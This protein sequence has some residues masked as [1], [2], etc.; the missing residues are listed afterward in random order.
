MN[1][2]IETIETDLATNPDYSQEQR[3]GMLDL[4]I[5]TRG[6]IKSEEARIAEKLNSD[7]VQL[8]RKNIETIVEVGKK[9]QLAVLIFVYFLKIIDRQNS[10]VIS[11]ETLCELF[12]V[13]RTTLWKAQ[14][15]LEESQ[16]IQVVKV[17]TA[18]ACAIN[19][20][21]AWTTYNDKKE[22]AIFTAKVV[23]SKKEQG[24]KK[25]KTSRF[26]IAHFADEKPF[27]VPSPEYLESLPA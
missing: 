21:I 25:V 15:V 1:E 23:A 5:K 13:G 20:E 17:G 12:G 22:L 24:S 11:Q 18:N 14:K 26:A 6:L 19:S 3:K 8:Y 10:V 4:L 16:F 27:A 7:F 2:K 9:S